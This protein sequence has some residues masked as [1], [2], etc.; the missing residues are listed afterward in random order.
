MNSNAKSQNQQESEAAVPADLADIAGLLDG[1]GS[2][3]RASMPLGAGTRIGAASVHALLHPDAAEVAAG[4]GVAAHSAAVEIEQ[5]PAG[6]EDRVFEA[7]R[8]E[9]A[10]RA[11]LRLVGADAHRAQRV[12]TRGGWWRSGVYRLAASV[13]IVGMGAVAFVSL[14]G[15]GGS[16]VPGSDV[17]VLAASFDSELAAFYDLLESAPSAGT[18]QTGH[19]AD[20]SLTEQLLDWESL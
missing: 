1:L 2:A 11:R 9:I 5:A 16:D 3:E 12:T 10:G 7:S 4:A 15:G 20:H 13:A 6:L 18:T 8:G 17:K 19:A 14:R